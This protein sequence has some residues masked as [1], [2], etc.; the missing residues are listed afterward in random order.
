MGERF[1]LAFLG[2]CCHYR[3]VQ[4]RLTMLCSL[5]VV[6]SVHSAIAGTLA[7][8]RTVLGNL[9]V[10]LYDQQRPI[11]VENFKR[12]VRS[13][14]FHNTFFHRLEPGFVVQGGGY[15]TTAP[16]LQ[17]DFAPPWSYFGQVPNFGAISNEFS[18][19]PRL[20]NTNGTIAM[21]K[22]PG[23]PDSATSEWFFNLGNNSANLDNQNGGFTVFGHVVRDTG[24]VEYGGLMGL[25]NV[26]SY[27]N[28][29]QNLQRYYGTNDLVAKLFTELPVVYPYNYAPWYSELLYVDVSLLNVQVT[30]KPNGSR[31]IS[32]NSVSN[33]LNYVEFTTNFPPVWNMLLSTN[34]DGSTLKTIDTTAGRRRFYR[35]RVAY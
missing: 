13:G 4:F 8:F 32:W 17:A 5:F 20:S 2:S 10:E 30:V 6:L 21:A 28:G 16:S 9:E 27:G 18:V 34:A 31:E 29:L 12:L 11:T 25:L 14:A 15:F 23:N 1:R 33:K 3:I 22:L 26:F 35:V 24:P 7:Q 19:G